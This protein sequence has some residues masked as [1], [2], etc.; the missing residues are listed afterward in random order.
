VRFDPTPRG[1]GANPATSDGLPFDVADYLDIE[2]TSSTFITGSSSTLTRPTDDE[3]TTTTVSIPTATGDGWDLPAIPLWLVILVGALVLGLGLIP[4]VKWARRRHRLDALATGDVA[5]AWREIVDRLADLGDDPSPGAT[6]VEVAHAT[7]P[8]MLPL[9]RVYGESIYGPPRGRAFDLSQVVTATRS[10]EETEGRLSGL[11]SPGRR[12]LARYRLR[13]LAP[14]RWRRARR[15]GPGPT[16][17]P[18]P[19]E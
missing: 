6:P 11:Y 2:V 8:A 13:S 17:P 14:R 3:E 1:D 9:A 7:D 5:G 18:Q 4:A 16:A 15:P 12:L 10:L 19:R